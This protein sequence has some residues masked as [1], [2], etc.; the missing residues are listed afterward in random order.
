MEIAR[1]KARFTEEIKHYW[2]QIFLAESIT[3]YIY[4]PS[5]P[6]RYHRAILRRN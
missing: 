1:L 4:N 6:S 3:F 2:L 5:L